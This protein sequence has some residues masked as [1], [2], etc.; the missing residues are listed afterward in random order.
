MLK[1]K[2]LIVED[3]INIRELIS[4]NLKNTGYNIMEADN[5]VTA[6]KIIK[7]QHPNLI[8]LDLMLPGIDGFEVCRWVRCD[9]EISDTPIIMLTAKNEE[10][11]RVLGLEL[12][13]DD[14][15]TKP[16]SMREMLA[17]V[18]AVLSRTTL[19]PVL[20]QIIFNDI[21]INFE[22]HEL[23]KDGQRV[24]LTLK[25]FELVKILYENR[26]K[27]LNREFLLDEIWGV[28]YVGETRTVDVHIRHLRQKIEKDDKNPRYIKTI[29]G[30][31]YSFN[32]DEYGGK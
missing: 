3:D 14:Y 30:V 4:F 8:L 26:G 20:N 16:F 19:K 7:T 2:I 10:F 21:I 15:I 31:G 22:K 5:C 11:D 25:E 1:E 18:K 12:G 17:R 13:A 32:I 6:I 28:E 29:R 24:E 23:L 9:N 27:V